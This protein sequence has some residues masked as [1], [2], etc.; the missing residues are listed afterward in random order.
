[1][2]RTR[3]R[4]LQTGYRDV[5]VGTP[6]SFF[7]NNT[8]STT[9]YNMWT[10]IPMNLIH[11]FMKIAN[12]YFLVLTILQLIPRVTISFGIPTYL[13]PLAFIVFLSMVK[14]AFEDYKRYKSDQE[15]NEKSCQVWDGKNFKRIQWS[16]VQ[17]GHL[18]RIDKDSFFPADLLLLGSSEFRKG[19]CFIETKNLDGETNLKSKVLPEEV[20]AAVQSDED[21]LKLAGTMINAEGPNQ[22]LSK[23]KGS[24]MFQGKKVPLSEANFLL[25]GCILRNVDHVFGVVIYTG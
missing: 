20:K 11:Q 19:I 9:K 10:F 22:Y 5:Q 2:R 21:V 13:A 24:M 8:V 7:D 15:E 3:R 18:V 1:V 25:R 12:I 6:L 17:V 16:Q 4:E 14:D 23:F